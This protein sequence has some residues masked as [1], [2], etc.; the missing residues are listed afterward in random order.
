MKKAQGG[1]WRLSAGA[2]AP[3]SW[4]HPLPARDVSTSPEVP[5][6]EVVR[7]LWRFRHVGMA[8]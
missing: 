3:W 5:E 2:P 4:V 8:D 1:A 6:P 7:F